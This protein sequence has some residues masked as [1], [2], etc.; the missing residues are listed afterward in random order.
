[1]D[2]LPNVVAMA[3]SLV[4][5]VS[6]SILAPK[7]GGQIGLVLKLVVVGVFFSV[8]LH[9]GVEL[10]EVRGLLRDGAIMALMGVLVSLGSVSFCAAA[11]VGLR[12]L[13]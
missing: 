6:L 5:I 10:A 1:V 9:A 8:F 3:T 13:R 11:V 7:L 12:A 2:S 4:A